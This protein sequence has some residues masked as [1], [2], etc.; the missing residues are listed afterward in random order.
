M[1][2]RGKLVVVALLLVGIVAALIAW[3]HQRQAGSRVLQMWGPDACYR[4][5]LAPSC[6]LL[7]LSENNDASPDRLTHGEQSWAVVRRLSLAQAKGLVHARQALIKD[8]S[9]TWES[10]RK[11]SDAARWTCALRFFDSSGETILLLDLTDAWATELNA[12]QCADM[13]PVVEG[14]RLFI[15]EQ[16]AANNANEPTQAVGGPGATRGK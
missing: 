7:E 12:D 14:F 1:E 16:F 4:I 5:R 13:Q 11:R 15:D 8:T 6:E 2:K 10:S 3:Q 9:Y